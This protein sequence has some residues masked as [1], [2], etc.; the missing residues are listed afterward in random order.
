MKEKQEVV[1]LEMNPI[2]LQVMADVILS[3]I[4]RVRRIIDPKQYRAL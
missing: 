2:P 1:I 3:R 4:N